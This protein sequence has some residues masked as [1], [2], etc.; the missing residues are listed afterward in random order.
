MPA[1]FVVVAYAGYSYHLP[2]F[3]GALASLAFACLYV[4][5]TCRSAD[6]SSR[7]SCTLCSR[8]PC[9]SSGRPH[10]CRS[11]LCAAYELRAGDGD[12]WVSVCSSASCRRTLWACWSFGISV[13]NAYTELLPISWRVRGWA[14]RE[15]MV[16][17]VYGVYLL[18]LLGVLGVRLWSSVRPKASGHDTGSS[19]R[20]DKG[21]NITESLMCVRHE[22]PVVQWTLGTV[23]LFA[24]GWAAAVFSFDAGQK[25]LLEVHHYAC[26]RMWPEVLE[27]RRRAPNSAYAR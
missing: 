22:T 26:R 24:V 13:V 27:A 11:R 8:R 20:R 2:L 14:T 18:S 23:V 3:M 5:L 4:R 21:R 16:A 19:G 1:I 17:V 25:A 12:R 15:K 7:P 9:L 6:S 10:C